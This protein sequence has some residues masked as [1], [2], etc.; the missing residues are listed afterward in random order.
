M[1]VQLQRDYWFN[2]FIFP[3]ICW[4]LFIYKYIHQFLSKI[5]ITFMDYFGRWEKLSTNILYCFVFFLIEHVILWKP[6]P[7]TNII[8]LN[9]IIGGNIQMKHINSSKYSFT[10]FFLPYIY[11][12]ISLIRVYHQCK[13]I[14]VIRGDHWQK[15]LY[16][17]NI[18]WSS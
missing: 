17:D 12:P 15:V 1:I 6:S 2:L 14:S 4:C 7:N 9:R 18:N 10:T 11:I 3:L 16:L 13:K 5:F 8:Q